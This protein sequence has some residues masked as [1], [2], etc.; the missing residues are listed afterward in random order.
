MVVLELFSPIK[1]STSCDVE[2]LHYYTKL[3]KGAAA[4]VKVLATSGTPNNVGL[5]SH[6]TLEAP[7]KINIPSNTKMSDVEVNNQQSTI[8]TQGMNITV[9]VSIQ[10]K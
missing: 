8:S 9:P 10:K 1:G 2:G 7:L 4:C 3:F 6:Y 5:P